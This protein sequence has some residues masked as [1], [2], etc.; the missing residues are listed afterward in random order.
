MLQTG[1]M[2]LDLLRV[3]PTSARCV[4]T[5]IVSAA[6]DGAD[7][8]ASRIPAREEEPRTPSITYRQAGAPARVVAGRACSGTPR[9][10]HP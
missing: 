8:G 2:F 7:S 4:E 3:L 5:R 1:K 9:L 6:A 10:E